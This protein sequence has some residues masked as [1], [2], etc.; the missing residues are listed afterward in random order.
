MRK[1]LVAG[2]VVFGLLLA[3]WIVAGAVVWSRNSYPIPILPARPTLPGNNAYVL[4]QDVVLGIKSK[5]EISELFGSGSAPAAAAERV[6]RANEGALD[7]LHVA[8]SYPSVVTD[9]EPKKEFVAAIDYPNVSRL[10]ILE[11][12]NRAAH[13]KGSPVDPVLDGVRFAEGSMK[14][15]AMLHLLTAY[16]AYTPLFEGFPGLVRSLS[17]EQC[18]SGANELKRI[19]Q[20]CE[21]LE[22]LVRNE[23]TVRFRQLTSTFPKPGRVFRFDIPWEEYE[24]SFTLKPKAPA[25]EGL[26]KYFEAWKAQAERPISQLSPPPPPSGLEGI[27][28]S[29]SFG[30]EEM[31]KRFLQFYWRD[32]RLRLVYTAL[33]LEQY[34]KE[35][36][37]YPDSLSTLGTDLLFTDPFS[38]QPLKYGRSDTEYTLYSVGPNG[39]DDGGASINEARLSPDR[40]GDLPL[41]PTFGRR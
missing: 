8:G 14:G 39:K 29:E 35:K 11:A 10:L 5:N 27:L 30:P 17:A 4:Y 20:D 12:R 40:S 41:Q 37:S 24:R 25:V 36:G 2:G 21:T 28:S 7:S 1:A 31:G 19:V 16:M 33:R 3:F 23:H 22:E 13:S 38:L 26:N 6:L 34:K 15:G 18:K 32:A 9:L